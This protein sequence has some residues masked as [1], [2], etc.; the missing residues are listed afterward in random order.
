[1]LLDPGQLRL[2]HRVTL[3]QLS[4]L[5]VRQH[6]MLGDKLVLRDVHEHLSISEMLKVVAIH[7]HHC[8]FSMG[9]NGNFDNENGW[10]FKVWCGVV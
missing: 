6:H 2:L 9:G 7:I 10:G 1:V 5:R 4:F 3:Q 8:F